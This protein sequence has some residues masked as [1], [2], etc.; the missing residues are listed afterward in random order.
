[1]IL[2]SGGLDSF[3]GTIEGIVTHRKKVVLVSHRSSTKIVG[4]QKHLVDQLRL[5]F[6]ADCLLHVPVWTTLVGRLGKEQTHRTRSFLFVALGTVVARLFDHDRISIFENGLVSLNYHRLPKSS[7][8]VL[9][10]PRTRKFWRALVA[11]FLMS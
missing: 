8:L 9:P 5:R 1:V 6:G 7:A 4:T 10:V 11:C 3:A 2:F